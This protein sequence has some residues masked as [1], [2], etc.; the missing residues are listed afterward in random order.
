MFSGRQIA[1]QANAGWRLEEFACDLFLACKVGLVDDSR[2][3]ETMIAL[4]SQKSSPISAA[5]SVTVDFNE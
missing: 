1:L 2:N 4:L 5:I 3:F